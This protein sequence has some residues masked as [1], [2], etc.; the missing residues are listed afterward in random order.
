LASTWWARTFLKGPTSP[1][2]A[3]LAAFG[4]DNRLA[5]LAQASGLNYSRY[6]DDLALSSPEHLGRDQVARM[7]EFVTR[8]AGE[9]GF[10]VNP[11]K[12]FVRRSGQRQRLACIVVNARPNVERREYEVLKATVHNEVLKATVHNAVRYGPASQNRVDHPRYQA[13]LLGRVSR[14]A[15]LNPARGRRL[16][17]AFAQI[18]WSDK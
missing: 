9:E 18:D 8:V 7:V 11:A 3:N 4:L 15:Q 6:A 16:L 17:T 14:V 13:H 10:R 2:L 12:T 1:A 5:G